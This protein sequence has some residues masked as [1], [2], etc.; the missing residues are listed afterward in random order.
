MKSKN[1]IGEIFEAFGEIVNIDLPKDSMG[2]NE[3]HAI[4]EFLTHKDAK[5]ACLHMN[6]SEIV[7]GQT[8]RVNIM[9]DGPTIATNNRVG[10]NQ[11]QRRDELQDSYI[12]SS[13]A[14]A[15]L[16][17]KLMG[18]KDVGNLRPPEPK[19]VKEEASA[20]MQL[21]QDHPSNCLLFSNMFDPRKVD[22]TKDPSF[23]I[24]LKDSI[25]QTCSDF[26][27][28]QQVYLEEKSE[29]GRIWVKF[30]SND[31]RGAARTQETLDNQFFDDNQIRVQFCSEAVFNVKSKER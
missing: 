14:R 31:V 4:I 16:M 26:G 22:L 9:T 3:G 13:Q 30:D 21:T 25:K 23:F 2:R 17:Q 6:G 11:N 28:V 1:A 24:E 27:K 8:L 19:P 10:Q 29:A 5:N 15:S 12:N 18:D 7:P 20:P